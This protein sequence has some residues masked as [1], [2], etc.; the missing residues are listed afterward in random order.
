[1]T[2]EEKNNLINYLKKYKKL[3]N[4]SAMIWTL[5][6]M[7]SITMYIFVRDNQKIWA[8][9]N[10]ILLI[11]LVIVAFVIGY[12]RN[13]ISE[14]IVLLLKDYNVIT[15]NE[16]IIKTY[17]QEDLIKAAKNNQTIDLST[18]NKNTISQE[19][20]ARYRST[21]ELL[22]NHPDLKS[23]KKVQTTYT[24]NDLILD[25][26]QVI[27]KICDDKILKTYILYEATEPIGKAELKNRKGNNMIKFKLE[28]AE[29]YVLE[30]KTKRNYAELLEKLDEIIDD[31]NE[32]VE[33]ITILDENNNYL[34]YSLE[35]GIGT[36]EDFKD[37]VIFFEEENVTFD[38]FLKTLIKINDY[39]Q[40]LGSEH[41]IFIYDSID[42][43]IN[44][45]LPHDPFEYMYDLTHSYKAEV[46]NKP[47]TD[48]YNLEAIKENLKEA[49][50]A[51]ILSDN[52]YLVFH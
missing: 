49:K 7:F 18:N 9:I 12:N 43:Y 52:R 50:N 26:Q 4:E 13:K 29:D 23:I 28:V 35:F 8:I 37:I 40:Y 42:H 30:I 47:L 25:Y 17:N 32:E 34:I 45:N 22:K 21:I 33:N 3:D 1:M 14:N 36:V 41:D 2:P 51:V 24:I 48:Y 38:N 31:D 39:D 20:D 44:E 11:I 5:L 10:F 46:G 19:I 16:K 27:I 15:I 6:F